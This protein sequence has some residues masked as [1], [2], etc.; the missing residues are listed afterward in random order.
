MDLTHL[1]V[2]ALS[3]GTTIIG[4]I[5]TITAALLFTSKDGS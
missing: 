2:T 3:A 1:P 4:T 5:T